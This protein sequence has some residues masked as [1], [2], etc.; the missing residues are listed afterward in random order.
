MTR[1]TLALILLA[2]CG[3]DSPYGLS[4]APNP[5]VFTRGQAIPAEMPSHAGGSINSYAV[6]PNLPAGLTLS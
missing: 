4:Y 3:T 2:A 1:I 5:G 6:S